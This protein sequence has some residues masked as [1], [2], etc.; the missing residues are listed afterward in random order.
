MD[1]VILTKLKDLFFRGNKKH[2]DYWILI[3]TLG[4]KY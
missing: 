2:D 3:L 4:E 1:F